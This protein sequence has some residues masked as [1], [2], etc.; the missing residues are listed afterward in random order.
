MR[1]ECGSLQLIDVTI[2]LKPRPNDGNFSTQHIGVTLLHTT[3]CVRLT[4]LL[5]VVSSDLKMVKFFMQHFWMLHC[6]FSNR[7]G[8]GMSL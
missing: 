6:L 5:G 7:E 4:T 1:K 3:C 8:L 2:N